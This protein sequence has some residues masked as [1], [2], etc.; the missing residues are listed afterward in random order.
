[1]GRLGLTGIAVSVGLMLALG[2]L[3]PSA[4]QPRYGTPSAAPP[5][6]LF[7]HPSDLVVYVMVIATLLFAAAGVGLALLAVRRGWS[8]SPRVLL[9]GGAAATVLL[10]LVPSMGSTDVLHY[11][12]SGRITALGGNP[13]TV[14][15]AQLAQT[16]D[17]VGRHA[18]ADMWSHLPSNYGPVATAMHWVAAQ[19]GGG[20]TLRTVWWIAVFN[21]AGFVATG[22]LLD[23]L[24]APDRRRR[25]RAQII[26]SLNPVLLWHLVVGAHVD[27]LAV[28]A[29]VTGFSALTLRRSG[30]WSGGLAG[31]AIGVACAIK[32]SYLVLVPGLVWALWH[33]RR[34]LAA[35]IAGGG[36]VTAVLYARYFPEAIL[37]PIQ[38]GT[39]VMGA[40]S[41]A[42]F[43]QS[44]A[45]TSLS[46]SQVEV[47]IA[48][49]SM[50]AFAALAG[51][52]ARGLP[53]G[54]GDTLA[55]RAARPTAVVVAAWLLTT[56]HAA[57]WYDAIAWALVPL[58]P[59]SWFV[60][61]LLAHTTLLSFGYLY[62]PVSKPLEPQW[63]ADLTTI[64]AMHLI[65]PL[66]ITGVGVLAAVLCVRARM[67]RWLPS[68]QIRIRR[69]TP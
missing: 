42:P 55:V 38:E 28:L 11:A 31:A 2:A 68:P 63:L 16:G 51:L 36:V 46:R 23:R 7:V 6:F 52:L 19:L 22:W 13:Y 65:I 49:A 21:G 69:T 66:C 17:P 35:G 5:W 45:S 64:D 8:P 58:L 33:D 44:L 41:W 25:V 57:P 26:W 10:L 14:T 62:L 53:P 47:I 48:G 1:M 50:V 29:A 43:L 20:S 54:Y 59:A 9:A 39:R 30:L 40:S 37:V 56:P 15:P 32:I 4:T 60:P 12:A 61:A 3:G 24:A 18:M 67:R 27:G 34:R